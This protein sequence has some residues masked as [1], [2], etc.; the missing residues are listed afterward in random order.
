MSSRSALLKVV[1]E[2]NR[3]ILVVLA[4]LLLACG[5][6]YLAEDRFVARDLEQ[7]RL[8]QA[9]LQRQLRQLQQRVSKDGM[10]LSASELIAKDL[11]D[12]NAKIPS[13]TKFADFIGDLFAWA[14]RVD[15]GIRQVSYQPKVEP[16]A[17]L[18][19]YGLSF[20]VQGDYG[21][22]KRFIHLLENSTRILIIDS[23]TLAG[24]PDL[25]GNKNEVTLNIKLTTY[26]QEEG[27]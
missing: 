20:S 21:Q 23:I 1:W 27:Q 24:R 26:F 17:G 12:F 6:L 11:D 4:L 9:T 7:L 8:E 2:Q 19:K 22:L 10:P 14:D 15:L 18:L 5:G 3:G 25:E 13:K 16:E